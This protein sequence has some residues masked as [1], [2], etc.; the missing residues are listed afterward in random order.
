[1][2]PHPHPHPDLE[3]TCSLLI[4][5]YSVLSDERRRLGSGITHTGNVS[6]DVPVDV[7]NRPSSSAAVPVPVLV[8]IP[9][10]VAPR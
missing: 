4:T 9:R 3:S 10:Y 5:Q 2:N 6:V 7:V 8:P 1:M